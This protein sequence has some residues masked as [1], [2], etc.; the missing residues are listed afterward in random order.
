MHNCK[1]CDLCHVHWYTIPWQLPDG[2]QR[3]PCRWESFHT[4]PWSSDWHQVLPGGWV[5]SRTRDQ[6][7]SLS[8]LCLVDCLPRKD[9]TL[10]H[11]ISEP[12]CTFWPTNC[13]AFAPPVKAHL[14]VSGSPPAPAS[15]RGV[16]LL[17]S[18]HSTSLYWYRAT[19]AC[20]D[21]ACTPAT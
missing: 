9:Y 11:I 12:H 13:L 14:M 2:R 18:L 8:N 19:T 7:H 20:P 6:L 5:R 1:Q 16:L 4:G 21:W 10:L 15:D 17:G 3:Q